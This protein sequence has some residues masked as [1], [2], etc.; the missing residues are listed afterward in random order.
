MGLKR[1]TSSGALIPSLRS[2][3]AQLLLTLCGIDSPNAWNTATNCLFCAN[4]LTISKCGKLASVLTQ[5]WYLAQ[6]VKHQLPTLTDMLEQH[7]QELQDVRERLQAA[8]T[9]R[10]AD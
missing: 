7:T 1:L 5:K 2:L 10:H 9:Q 6:Q 8:M 4:R 3:F